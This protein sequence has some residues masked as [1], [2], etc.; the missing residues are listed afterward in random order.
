MV[1]QKWNKIDDDFTHY[2]VFKNEDLQFLRIKM[3][4]NPASTGQTLSQPSGK[5]WTKTSFIYLEEGMEQ[6]RIRQKVIQRS[7]IGLQWR[8]LARRRHASQR[9][10]NAVHQ[11]DSLVL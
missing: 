7:F 2:P 8:G 3:T 5:D 6:R 1:I 4:E 11:E 9:R 10:N